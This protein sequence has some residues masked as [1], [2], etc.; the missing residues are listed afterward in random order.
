M[1][2]G[3]SFSQNVQQFLARKVRNVVCFS[4]WSK[5]AEFVSHNLESVPGTDLQ[6]SLR[7]ECLLFSWES[8]A[9]AWKKNLNQLGQR[10]KSKKQCDTGAFT[11]EWVTALQFLLKVLFVYFLVDSPEINYENNGCFLSHADCCNNENTLMF[12]LILI[13]W[14]GVFQFL[15]NCGEQVYAGR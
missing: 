5:V 3:S 13:W 8:G 4:A 11:C 12:S 6:S 2:C 7:W 1:V 9:T 15:L 10:G 14:T